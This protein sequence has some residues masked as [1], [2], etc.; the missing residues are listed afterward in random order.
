[1]IWWEGCASSK[2]EHD[3][4][5]YAILWNQPK[6]SYSRVLDVKFEIQAVMVDAGI[7]SFFLGP[8]IFV[9]GCLSLSFYKKFLS[10]Q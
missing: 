2:N 6:E 3:V 10:F 7:H 4:G 1:L 8:D 9:T 5:H